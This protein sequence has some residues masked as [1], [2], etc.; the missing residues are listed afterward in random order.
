[1]R[2]TRRYRF[3]ASHR[4]HSPSLSEAENAELYGKCN[5]PYGHGHNYILEIG[6]RGNVDPAIGRVVSIAALD[7]YVSE[8]VV[9]IYDHHDMNRDIPDFVSP[10][11]TTEN[12][13]LDVRRRLLDGWAASFPNATLDVVRIRETARNTFELRGDTKEL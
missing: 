2:V 7:G 12:M 13:S 11:P 4:L 10:I 6:I 8:R 5:Y 3:S 9:R 1:M